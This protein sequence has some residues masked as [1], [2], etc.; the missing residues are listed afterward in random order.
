[1]DAEPPIFRTRTP[2]RNVWFA[3]AAVAILVEIG[4]LVALNV[5]V[6]PRSEFPTQR[7]EPLIGDP[8]VVKLNFYNAIDPPPRTLVLGSSRVM[9]LPPPEIERY[10]PAPAFNFGVSAS[11][12]QDAR[13]IYEHAVRD[14][15]TPEA[16]LVGVDVNSLGPDAQ[17]GLA[18][19]PALE[20]MTGKAPPVSSYAAAA[21]GSLDALYVRDTFT[22]LWYNLAGYPPRA[23]WFEPDGLRHVSEREDFLASPD[24]TVEKAVARNGQAVRDIVA[25]ADRLDPEELDHLRALVVAARANGTRVT[26]FV[27]PFHPLMLE[28]LSDTAFMTVRAEAVEAL[29]GLCAPGV[30][31][32][33]LTDIESFSGDYDD[34][35]DAWHYGPENAR[36]ILARVYAGDAG[37]CDG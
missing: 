18:T 8:S 16:V 21:V 37:L 14:G 35:Y 32:F 23:I 5:T 3:I 34:F 27:T 13:V 25:K 12:L 19:S 11:G 22:V 15:K 36:R 28:R 30:S 20:R 17:F 2:P 10:A 1:M 24:F 33:D 29:H 31:V 4:T 26:L 7:L 9:N 6:N